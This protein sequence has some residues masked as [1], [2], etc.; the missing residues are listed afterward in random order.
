MKQGRQFINCT[1][2]DIMSTKIMKE[3]CASW[4]F[5]FVFGCWLFASVGNLLKFFSCYCKNWLMRVNGRKLP[6]RYFNHWLYKI[7]SAATNSNNNNSY[8]N[9]NNN[10]NNN[11][12]LSRISLEI[13]LLNIS[14]FIT[15]IIV[16]P[17]YSCF[18]KRHI[19][20]RLVSNF[21]FIV[22]SFLR[23]VGFASLCSVMGLRNLP[24]LCLSINS[25]SSKQVESCIF[26]YI[27]QIYFSFFPLLLV[28]FEFVLTANVTALV[29]IV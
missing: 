24:F 20:T 3:L 13:D 5:S 14:C 4:R 28:I 18:S 27:R 29:L 11:K 21:Q 25:I 1:L 15:I 12:I 22:E 10:N 19:L 9:N 26:L 17:W 23:L 16:T 6:V 8:N 2:K 7:F